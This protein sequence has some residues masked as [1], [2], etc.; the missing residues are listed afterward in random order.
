MAL[1]LSEEDVL[2]QI[3]DAFQ[4]G[5]RLSDL[6]TVNGTNPYNLFCEVLDEDGESKKASLASLMPYM[7]SECSYGIEF[8]TAV[9]SP[10]CTRIGNSDLHKSLPV[11]SL[12]K[13][14]TLGDDGKVVDYLPVTDWTGAVRDGSRGQVMVEL[15]LYY[16]KCETEGTKRRVRI[17][18]QPLA[19][20]TQVPK[21]YISAYEAT[22]D[23][24]GMKLASV[25]NESAQYRGGNDNTS[26]D[27]TC[28]SFLGRPATAISRG[29]FRTYARNRG[30]VGKNNCGW[31]CMTYDAAKDIYW[32]FAIEYATLNSQAAYNAE[33]TSEGYR[34]GGLGEGVTS[35]GS[36]IGTGKEHVGATTESW[37]V[38]N[39]SNPFV[40][41]GASDTLGNGTGQVEYSVQDG[42][43]QAW[44]DQFVPRYRGIE[45]PFG[46]VWHWTDGINVR[47]NPTAENGG[48]GLSEVF[49]CDD[50]SKFTDG[51]YDGYSFVGLEAR[52][53]DYVKE[54][55][56]GEGGE[57]MPNVCGG[58]AGS[59][60]YL[61][62]YHNTN[63]PTTTAFRGVLFGGNS[64]LG[65][66]AGLVS[67]SSIAAPSNTTASIGSR[68]CFLP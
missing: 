28:R 58:G 38:F 6:P 25:F 17:S 48:S 10:T 39:G 4:N 47:I 26:Y 19:G 49:V 63:I 32:L 62:D 56:F 42:D 11:Q 46:H 5:K 52:N 41:C 33:L 55:I 60:T 18:L 68:L 7:E 1:T 22:V 29:T 16:R 51:G 59:T 20:Y 27:G 40:P 30:A 43:T 14:C 8:D 66:A 67:A 54:L 65:T 64:S 31:N 61:C 34:Q 24:T 37:A 3:I 12:M 23:R 36:A 2:K 57:I 50:P 15:P 13:G 44:I 45:N 53:I 21:K 9:S 35:V